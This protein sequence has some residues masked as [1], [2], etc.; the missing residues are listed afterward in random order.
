MPEP[1]LAETAMI[2]E[3]CYGK[4]MRGSVEWRGVKICPECQGS[5]IAYCCDKAGENCNGPQVEEDETED[6]LAR[7]KKAAS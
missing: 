3:H 4:G 5:G 7:H 2:C 1:I 6:K